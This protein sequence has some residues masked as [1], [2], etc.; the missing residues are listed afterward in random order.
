MTLIAI[1]VDAKFGV[2]ELAF[3]QQTLFRAV[4]VKNSFFYEQFV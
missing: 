4:S 2:V 3:N 1:V